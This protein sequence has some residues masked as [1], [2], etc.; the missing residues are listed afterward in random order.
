[1]PPDEKSD[2]AKVLDGTKLPVQVKAQVWADYFDAN[3]PDDF[4][5]R[6][7]KLNLPVE[8]KRDL[9][10]KKYTGKNV[11]D[12]RDKEAK[13][14]SY[15]GGFGR[16]AGQTFKGLYD[17]FATGP[18]TP[19]EK[20]I[21]ALGGPVSLPLHR[22]VSGF[23]DTEKEAAKQ[24]EE[25]RKNKE[26]LR[27][28]V[29][30]ASMKNPFATGTVVDVNRLENE[31]RHKEAV[32][33]AAFDILSMLI[34]SRFGREIPPEAK[35]NKLTYAVGG[36]KAELKNVMPDLAKT[37]E[38]LGQPQSVGDLV[39][40]VDATLKTLNN[41]YNVALQ[42][43]RQQR[44]MPTDIARKLLDRANKSNLS[45]TAAGRAE[46][47]ALRKAALD[48]QRPWSIEQLD[49]E[50]MTRYD[51]RMASKNAVG[52]MNAMKSSVDTAIDK[53][54]EDGSKDI[55]YSE[56]N[57]AYPWKDFGDLKGRQ[58]SLLDLKVKLSDQVTKLADA[59]AMKQGKPFMAKES[60]TAY[61]HPTGGVGARLH[62]LQELLP[63]GGPEKAANRAVRQSS[64]PTTA[65]TARRAAVLSLP[66]TTLASK[67]QAQKKEQEEDEKS[68]TPL[69]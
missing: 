40:H 4:V 18:Q 51:H 69:Q 58:S 33:T 61:A 14:D 54:V 11:Q 13:P 41:E 27:A 36:N 32:G 45:M 50:R 19:E 10:H 24:V 60:V 8:T 37:A 53:I 6:M 42:P 65:A 39:K 2:I 7:D 64:G 15:L 68:L 62:G 38:T 34:G 57:K 47:A 20:G 21:M 9:W 22:I 66:I 35:L 5:K 3:G 48:F 43:I 49:Q 63:G 46:R 55:V 12:L 44:I 52:Q 17:T 26:R 56:L 30:Q 28:G 29:T 23:V 1:M 25:Q 59:Q 16:R 67:R 31:N